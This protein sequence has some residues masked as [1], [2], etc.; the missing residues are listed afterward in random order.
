MGDSN[1]YL[2]YILPHNKVE[3][4]NPVIGQEA[5]CP[6]GLGRVNGIEEGAAGSQRIRVRTYINNRDCL[7]DSKNIRLVR[8]DYEESSHEER[9]G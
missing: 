8:I 1:S 6:D 5:V 9:S 7:W 3:P 4:M 2:R